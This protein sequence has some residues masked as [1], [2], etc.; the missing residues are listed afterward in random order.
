[1][2]IRYNKQTDALYISLAKGA[3]TVSKKITDTIIVDIDK[4][5][6]VMGIEILDASNTIDRFN[7][8]EIP[9]TFL[10]RISS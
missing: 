6:K 2:N 10:Q 9:S 7:P 5:G 4:K 8:R 3:Y 1:M